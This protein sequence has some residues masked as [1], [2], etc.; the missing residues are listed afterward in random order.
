MSLPEQAQCIGAAQ[1]LLVSLLMFNL[2]AYCFCLSSSSS[3]NVGCAAALGPSR[4][5]ERVHY[6]F[7]G[8]SYLVLIRCSEIHVPG[9]IPALSTFLYSIRNTSIDFYGCHG[10]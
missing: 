5:T 10:D 1:A 8:L 9:Q 3:Y 2:I 7:R 6:L 4:R